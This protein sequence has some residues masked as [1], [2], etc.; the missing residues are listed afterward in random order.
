MSSPSEGRVLAE[1]IQ[2]CVKKVARARQE[3]RR[4][5]VRKRTV[6]A[7]A[8][9]N[10]GENGGGRRGAREQAQAVRG[11]RAR[12]SAPHSRT[13][14]Q[15]S[16]QVAARWQV[17]EALLAHGGRRQRGGNGM[18]QAAGRAV[19][20]ERGGAVRGGAWHEKARAQWRCAARSVKPQQRWQAAGSELAQA[21]RVA[22]GKGGSSGKKGKGAYRYKNRA[23]EAM[24][25]AVAGIQGEGKV[26]EVLQ[27]A[28]SV[29]AAGKGRPACRHRTAAYVCVCAGAW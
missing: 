27:K 21:R 29:S 8:R 17:C 28:G 6:R 12:E 4:A 26:R 18:V 22:C 9:E 14:N 1:L 15:C 23:A 2:T 25:Q 20:S 16:R 13:A 5:Q 10:K 19:C 3:R 11:A 24:P 7:C